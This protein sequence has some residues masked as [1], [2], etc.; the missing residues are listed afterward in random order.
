M[1]QTTSSTRDTT[2]KLANFSKNVCKTTTQTAEIVNICQDLDISDAMK[3]K[4]L[5]ATQHRVPFLI[6]LEF[7]TTKI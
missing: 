7:K 4:I 2:I 5:A 1:V 3:I 6:F